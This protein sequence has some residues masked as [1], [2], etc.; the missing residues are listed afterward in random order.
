M[1][2]RNFLAAIGALSV[3]S[4]GCA[5]L[6]GKPKQQVVLQISDDNVKT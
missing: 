6:Q 3:L 4:A 1:K 2:R 5:P